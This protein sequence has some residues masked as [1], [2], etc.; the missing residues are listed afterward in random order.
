MDI[1]DETVGIFSKSAASMSTIDVSL[2]PTLNLKTPSPKIA[3]STS[4]PAI[5]PKVFFIG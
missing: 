1:G 3:T 4:M 5:I 2:T